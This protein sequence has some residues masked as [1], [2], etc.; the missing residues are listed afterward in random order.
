MLSVNNLGY[1]VSEIFC[2]EDIS[3]NLSPGD[4]LAILG[5]NG[6]G[7]TTLLRLILRDLIPESGTI[8][9]DDGIIIGYLPQ[10]PLTEDLSLY[11]FLIKHHP[12]M[13]N[14]YLG[15]N[16]S[17]PGTME[18]ASAIS[19][20]ADA[21][22]YRLET[23]IKKLLPEFNFSESD[24]ER[25][26]SSF[27]K[28]QQQ[29]LSLIRIMISSADLFI[30][31]EPLNHLDISMRLF[32]ENWI[33]KMKNKGKAFL[34]VSHD[35]VFVDRLA[36][37]SLY[38]QRGNSILVHGGYSILLD[39]LDLVLNAKKDRAEQ[40]ERKI[41]KLENE[42]RRKKTWSFR[43]EKEKIGSADKGA[44][45]HQAAKLMKKSILA[46]KRREQMISELEEK[47][48]FIEKE[49]NLEF[50]EYSVSRRKIFELD[51]ICK[52]FG[53]TDIIKNFSLSSDT[54]DRIGIIG[55]NGSG[56]TTILRIIL[57]KLNPDSGTSYINQNV[58]F[59]YIPQDIRRFFG[60]E[61]LI[62]NFFRDD[63]DETRIR[64]FLG[65]AKIRGNKV[66]QRT[67]TLSYG[68][69]MKSAIVKTILDKSEFLFL[70]EPTNHLDLES[71]EV[72]DYLLNQF[73]GGFLFI[74]HDR[75]FIAS[76]SDR[77]IKLNLD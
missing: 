17:K 50:P 46:K 6:S 35:R 49:M 37:Q 24:L 65:S 74:S 16:N 8:A 58:Q 47:K 14:Y 66:F 21:G 73:P 39:H 76:H 43:K 32:F 45:G 7:K 34:V 51:N 40:L 38:I 9:L 13:F 22:G 64:M 60:H 30:L 27:S 20:Y 48:P 29:I 1:E 62:D 23:E 41:S 42:F 68:E 44:I 12:L 55:P 59:S 69:L 36:D 4:F 15:I 61:I 67:T 70:D 18:Y 31:D 33:Q 56:K 54:L 75:Y 25:N 5:P 26:V 28:G 77:L 72:I 19:G 10:E 11:S 63:L 2:L 52:S 53:G 57:N 71:L 3:F